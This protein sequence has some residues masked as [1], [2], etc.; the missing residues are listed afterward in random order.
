MMSNRSG[1]DTQL[2]AILDVPMAQYSTIKSTFRIGFTV[3]CRVSTAR[4][5]IHMAA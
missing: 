1:L 3:I 2:V 4:R 5:K